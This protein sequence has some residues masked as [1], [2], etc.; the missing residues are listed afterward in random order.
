MFARRRP[1]H[2]LI[3]TTLHSRPTA[4]S[5]K[6][7][8]K[9]VIRQRFGRCRSRCRSCSRH[10]RIEVASLRRQLSL[11][12]PF[13]TPSLDLLERRGSGRRQRISR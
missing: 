7:L 11:D 4:T 9:I 2:F 8:P 6:H 1:K 5:L 13:A 12:A 10:A 3:S